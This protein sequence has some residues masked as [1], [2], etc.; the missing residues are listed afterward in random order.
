MPTSGT[1]RFKIQRAT[2]NA[3]VVC[4]AFIES[5]HIS[6]KKLNSAEVNNRSIWYGSRALLG[7]RSGK[8]T[9][10]TGFNRGRLIACAHHLAE[11]DS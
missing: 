1:F 7:D 3:A 10:V 11:G 6:A 2:H 5:C 9:I 4:G 8:N